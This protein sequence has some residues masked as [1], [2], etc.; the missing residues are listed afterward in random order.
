VDG[1][2]V[3]WLAWYRGLLLCCLKGLPTA[4]R[5]LYTP[6]VVLLSPGFSHHYTFLFR[7]S[8]QFCY[9]LERFMTEKYIM[10][11]SVFS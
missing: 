6:F 1:L 8:Q 10:V 4:F 9:V 3:R 5:P 11:S 7:K 2:L